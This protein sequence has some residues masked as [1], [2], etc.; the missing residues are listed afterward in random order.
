MPPIMKERNYEK[1]CQNHFPTIFDQTW[2]LFIYVVEGSSFWSDDREN[3]SAF[4][5]TS[6][7]KKTKKNTYLKRDSRDGRIDNNTVSKNS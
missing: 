1:F 6:L 3:F 2:D 7:R 4:L 5:R